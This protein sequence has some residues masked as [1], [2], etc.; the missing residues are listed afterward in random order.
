MPFGGV[1]VVGVLLEADER[2]D[3]GLQ[4]FAVER[5]GD[6][7]VGAGAQAADLVVAGVQAR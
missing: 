2:S 4:L 7:I 5:L 3:P 6:E 1:E